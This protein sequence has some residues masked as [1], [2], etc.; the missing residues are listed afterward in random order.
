MV[1]LVTPQ[2]EKIAPFSYRI[3]IKDLRRLSLRLKWRMLP[4]D[5]AF[6]PIS[7]LFMSLVFGIR[8]AGRMG[9]TKKAKKKLLKGAKWLN[10]GIK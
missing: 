3:G 8:N 4:L 1:E 9:M 2:G 6:G 7:P 5:L 10:R